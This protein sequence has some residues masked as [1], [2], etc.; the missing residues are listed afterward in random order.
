VSY[1]F[2]CARRT[3]APCVV[4]VQ[5]IARI[6]LRMVVR[7]ADAGRHQLAAQPLSVLARQAVC[8][9]VQQALQPHRRGKESTGRRARGRAHV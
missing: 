2:S 3:P 8:G 7:G 9:A 5:A 6:H 1:W 4:R